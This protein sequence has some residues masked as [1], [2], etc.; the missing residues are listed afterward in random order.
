M[1][2]ESVEYKPISKANAGAV[3]QIGHYRFHPHPFQV[4]I[5][6]RILSS[7]TDVSE[8]HVTSILRV[9]EEAKQETSVKEVADRP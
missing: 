5:H 4:I 6:R 2:N 7:Q 9:E 8:E 1:K 3:P